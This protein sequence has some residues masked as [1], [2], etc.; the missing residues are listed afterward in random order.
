MLHLSADLSS[1]RSVENK[2]MAYFTEGVCHTS[3]ALESHVIGSGVPRNFV[4]GGGGGGGGC[5]TFY[6]PGC[7]PKI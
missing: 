4:R 1:R 7:C 6:H 3:C 2:L 5:R